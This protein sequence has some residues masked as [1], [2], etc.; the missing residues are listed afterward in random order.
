MS[1]IRFGSGRLRA[2]FFVCAGLAAAVALAAAVTAAAAQERPRLAPPVACTLGQDCYIQQYVDRDPGPGVREFAC[3]RLATNGHKGTD[4]ALPTEAEMRAGVAVLAAAPGT[5]ARL[6]DGMP[7]I[8][9]G[10]AGAPDVTGRDC[11]NGVVVDHGGGWETQYCHL[12]QGS[13]A[14]RRGER[15]AAG[16]PLGLVGMSGAASFPHLH[17]SV[18]HKGRVVD[19]FRP[20]AGPGCGGPE[21]PLWAAPVAYDSGRLLSAGLTE[22]VP[23]Y[24]AIKAGLPEDGLGPAAP[25]AVLWAY[26][27]NGRAGDVIDFEITSPDGPFGRQEVVLETDQPFLFRAWGR[28]AP[29]DGLPAGRW[30]GRVFLRR[31]DAILGETR[32]SATLP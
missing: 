24:D 30:E 26:V 3:G 21:R 8:R 7:D 20:E 23:D 12:R 19:P 4:I 5:V 11:G 15:V 27:A 18:R 10:T 25:A 6:R 28:R 31:A 13:V 2:P 22:E 1:G 29:P 16:A 17:L 14:V 9:Q 32:V